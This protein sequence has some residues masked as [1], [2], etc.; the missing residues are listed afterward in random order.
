MKGYIFLLIVLLFNVVNGYYDHRNGWQFRPRR[1]IHSRPR[2]PIDLRPP[3]PPVIGPRTLLDVRSLGP[4]NLLDNL[5]EMR[6]DFFESGNPDK[7]NRILDDAV[8]Y[9]LPPLD[10]Y[11]DLS[12]IYHLLPNRSPS[13]KQPLK[14]PTDRVTRGPLIGLARY[15]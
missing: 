6:D 7:Y 5:P 1:P 12:E 14:F 3:N 15:R 10:D 2:R 8:K 13:Q 4:I 11:L 9:L